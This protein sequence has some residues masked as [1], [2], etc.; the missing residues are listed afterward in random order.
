[1]GCLVVDLLFIEK[2]LKGM[3]NS[4]EATIYHYLVLDFP[5]DLILTNKCFSVKNKNIFFVPFTVVIFLTNKSNSD[6]LF[7]VMKSFTVVFLKTCEK[8]MPELGLMVGILQKTDLFHDYFLF[9]RKDHFII[10]EK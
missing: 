1:M 6:L 10:H 4:H 3:R 8:L 5:F 7:F 2:K 9:L